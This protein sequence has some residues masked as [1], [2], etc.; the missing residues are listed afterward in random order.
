MADYY[1]KHSYDAL[2]TP[3]VAAMSGTARAFK[4]GREVS[5]LRLAAA[6]ISAPAT[7][8][9]DFSQ[10]LVCGSG[11]AGTWTFKSYS[12][13]FKRRDQIIAHGPLPPGVAQC[14]YSTAGSDFL[15]C[16]TAQVVTFP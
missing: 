3:S 14:T 2:C 6:D 13:F 4:N 10:P 12:R 11:C 15:M 16:T 5:A 7:Y 8:V 9:S 1:V